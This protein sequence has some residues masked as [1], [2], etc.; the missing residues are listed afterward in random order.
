MIAFFFFLHELI[1]QKFQ[2]KEI[3]KKSQ[4]IAIPFDSF[5]F[6]LLPEIFLFSFKNSFFIHFILLSSLFPFIC[7]SP[8]HNPHS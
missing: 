1:K 4:I 8:I 3:G 2:V 7:S 5:P 6:I